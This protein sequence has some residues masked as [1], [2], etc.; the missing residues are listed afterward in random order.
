L[1]YSTN[2]TAT[3]WDRR[4]I[5]GHGVWTFSP[6]NVTEP[7]GTVLFLHDGDQ[8]IPIDRPIW[9]Q[10]FEK[11][12][13]RVIAPEGGRAWWLNQIV[14]RFDSR[15]SS[16]DFIVQQILPSLEGPT[17][18]TESRLG[19]MG[20]GMGGQGALALAYR[21]PR[22]F[23]AVAAIAPAIDFHLLVPHE[24]DILTETFGSREWARQHTAILAVHPLNWPSAQFVCCD[25]ADHVWFDSA[26][27]LRMKLNSI[28]IPLT[29]ELERG[30]GGYT[31]EYFDRMAQP[32]IDFVVQGLRNASLRI[33]RP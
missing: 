28:G 17:E 16:Q 12:G 14:P 19:V 27:R 33:V 30:G 31:W 25:P 18:G 23:P 32:S 5:E 3:S 20:I 7:A 4:E 22:R 1:T 11:A 15:W 6:P 21:F 8:I 24:D 10:A 13:V 26:D 9:N 29:H 2:I